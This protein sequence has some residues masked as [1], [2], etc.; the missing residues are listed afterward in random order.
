MN[1]EWCVKEFLT[2]KYRQQKL[3]LRA[4]STPPSLMWLI[5]VQE[6]ENIPPIIHTIQYANYIKYNVVGDAFFRSDDFLNFQKQLRND[7]K[8]AYDIIR[9]APPWQQEWD[10]QAW[11]GE[12][13]GVIDDYFATNNDPKQGFLSW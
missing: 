1:S 3:N 13:K 2:I 12:I 9:N 6:F 11:K 7:V 4:G 5:A 10:T 8:A